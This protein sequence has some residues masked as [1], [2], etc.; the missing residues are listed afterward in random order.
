M[1]RAEAQAYADLHRGV[2]ALE[3]IANALEQAV[4]G[5]TG[6]EVAAAKAQLEEIVAEAE[7]LGTA[8]GIREY[9]AGPPW[10][11]RTDD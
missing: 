11:V 10:K 5:V 4:Y 8:P 7:R 6:A 9:V 1:T 2:D 3:R